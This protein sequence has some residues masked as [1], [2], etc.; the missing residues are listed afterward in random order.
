L[1]SAGLI[2]D[3]THKLLNISCSHESWIHTSESYIRFF[4]WSI[5][6]WETLTL[7]AYSLPTCNIPVLVF[8]K[9][10]VLVSLEEGLT[11]AQRNIQLFTSI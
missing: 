3:Q 8:R 2:S 10:I 6:K 11:H 7:I 4:N 9:I 5:K 1:W